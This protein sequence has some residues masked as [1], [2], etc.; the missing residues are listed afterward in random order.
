MVHPLADAGRFAPA[1]A[2]I[3]ELGATDLAAAHDLDR[4]DHRRIEREDALDAFAIRNLPHGEVLVQAAAGAADADTFISLHAGALALDDLD[5][6]HDGIPRL[7]IGNFLAGGKLCHLFGFD[8][9]EQ[10]HGKFSIGC[11]LPCARLRPGLSGL[12]VLLR[13]RAA[14]VTLRSSGLVTPFWEAREAAARTRSRG[15]A[16][17]LWSAVRPR[18]AARRRFCRGLR[19][20]GFP[21]SA[22]PPRAGDGCTEGIPEARR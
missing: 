1:A 22:G 2:Q 19:T 8:L 5:V 15:P 20:T 18:S 14:F 21:G 13:H 12:G 9:F 7:E 11:A 17:V 3:I 4:V 10:V 6:D 16:G